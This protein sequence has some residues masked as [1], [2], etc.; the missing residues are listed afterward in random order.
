VRHHCGV[1]LVEALSDQLVGAHGDG[2]VRVG[3]VEVGGLMV[4]NEHS[5]A[6]EVDGCSAVPSIGNRYRRGTRTDETDH[7]G[8]EV[9]RSSSVLP[10]PSRMEG[11]SRM[12][13]RVR[14]R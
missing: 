4:V 3:A 5:Q 2:I 6:P 10:P 8:V 14:R 1:E 13:A 11:R 12:Q 7:H 9:G